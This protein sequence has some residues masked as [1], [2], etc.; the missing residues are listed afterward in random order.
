MITI[1][2]G[3]ERYCI[4]ATMIE[5]LS[6]GAIWGRCEGAWRVDPATIPM[7]WGL[8]PGPDG[9]PVFGEYEVTAC[10]EPREWDKEE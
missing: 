10:Y 7:G 4:S 1:D 9:E 5:C 2:D 6:C 3:E 8:V